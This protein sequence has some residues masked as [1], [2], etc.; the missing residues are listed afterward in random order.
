MGG[1]GC[2]A[3]GLTSW[4][5]ILREFGPMGIVDQAALRYHGLKIPSYS[6]LN[7]NL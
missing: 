6:F 1:Y 3:L 5:L 7:Q 4:K 2:I